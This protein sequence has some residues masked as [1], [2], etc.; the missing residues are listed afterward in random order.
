MVKVKEDLT[1][2]TFGRLTVIRQVEDCVRANGKHMPQWLCE[3]SCSE[4]NKIIVLGHSLKTGNTRSCGCIQK[5]IAS[6]QGK[7][8][9]KRNK[10]DP[11]IH[12]DNNGSY[13]IGYTSNTNMPFYFDAENYDKIKD[14]CWYEVIVSNNYHRLEAYNSNLQM[15]IKFHDLIG[16]A[17]HDHIDRNPLNNRRSNLRKCTQQENH[18]NHS[19]R[20]DNTSGV[21]G[22]YWDALRGKWVSHI[23]INGKTKFLGRFDTKDEAI[24]VRLQAELKYFKDFAPQKHLYKQY[25]IQ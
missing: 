16:G 17:Y 18:Y 13:M 21:T 8:R 1:G 14:Y 24:K 2:R 5:E 20:I 11:I 7:N 25:N 22:V 3:C 10:Y 23:G 19:L 9:I 15:P 6:I 12:I 4:H